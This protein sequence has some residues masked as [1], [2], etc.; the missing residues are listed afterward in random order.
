MFCFSSPA[1]VLSVRRFEQ[2]KSIA[3]AVAAVVCAQIMLYYKETAF[4]LL[5]GFAAGRLILRLRN[6]QNAAMG[7]PS[8]LGWESRP[9]TCASLL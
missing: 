3:W 7:S 9:S 5:F 8:T 2:T 4:L 6:A 1:L